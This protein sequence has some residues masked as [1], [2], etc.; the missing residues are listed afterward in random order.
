MAELVRQG[1]TRWVAVVPATAVIAPGLDY[2]LA[3]GGTAVFA[4]ETAPHTMPVTISVAADRRTRDEARML[5]RRSRIHT[6]GEYVSYGPRK[7]GGTKLE[8]SYY[9]IDADFL[10]RLWAYPLEELRVGT[11]RLIGETAPGLNMPCPTTAPCTVTAGYRVAG[12]FELGLAPIEGFH[13]DL[14]AAVMAT[15]E[16]FAVGGRGEVRLGVRDASHVALGVDYMADVGVSGFFRLGWGT[17]PGF[18]M[19]ASVE[20]TNLPLTDTATAV[21]LYY[22]IGRD[23][24][25]GFRIGGRVGYAARSQLHAGFTGGG[26]VSVDF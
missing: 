13:L 1:D 6:S 26:N 4:T 17:V 10:Y 24:G 14:R 9:R 19:A 5:G 7:V 15:A 23:L 11:T 3:A 25:G 2:Y 22:D 12:W 18:P 21:R 20:I 16:G 8:D